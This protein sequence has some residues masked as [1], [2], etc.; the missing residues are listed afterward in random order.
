L[1]SLYTFN[2][3]E[4]ISVQLRD[5]L[6]ALTAT[7]LT[8]KALEA[9]IQFQAEQDRAQG[10][11]L[12]QYDG[13]PV[14]VGKSNDVAERLGQHL[15]KLMGRRGVAVQRI[16]YKTL[17][18]DDSMGTAASEDVLI[19]LFKRKYRA[20]W[21][22]KGFGPKDPGQQRDT[23]KPS[24][25]DTQFPIIPDYPVV[26]LRNSEELGTV[27][28]AMKAQLPYLFRFQVG[29]PER[30]IKLGLRGVAREA[31]ALLKHIVTALGP[32]WHGAVISYGMVLYK[33]QKEY[34]FGRVFTSAAS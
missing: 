24:W 23:T 31:E 22:G 8:A 19:K 27:L 12:L 29:E 10:V 34:K 1:H 15:Q 9:L 7:A 20:M 16:A 25:F 32:G 26:G 30:A 28:E 2:F 11:Y 14:Y 17:L 21:N 33:G 5:S 13:Q 3:L 6:E 18:L 4:T